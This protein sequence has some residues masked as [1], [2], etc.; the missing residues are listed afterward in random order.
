MAVH[1]G[2][3][4][5]MVVYNGLLHFLAAHGGLWRFMVVYGALW[6]SILTLCCAYGGLLWLM[7]GL[8]RFIVLWFI[9]IYCGLC[10]FIVVHSGF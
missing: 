8:W 5:F 3:L 10:R 9:E 4:R 2:L 1:D 7:A 6:W